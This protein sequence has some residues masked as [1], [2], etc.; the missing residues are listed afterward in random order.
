MNSSS[1]LSTNTRMFPWILYG[2]SG[3]WGS[4]REREWKGER[5]REGEKER[6]REGERGGGR[7]RVHLQYILAMTYRKVFFIIF[8]LVVQL[9]LRVLF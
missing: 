4:E 6:E 5:E 8:E 7:V 3:D 1:I 2:L 9:H